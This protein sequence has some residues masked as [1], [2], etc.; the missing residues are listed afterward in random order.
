MQLVPVKVTIANGT[1]LSPEVDLQ[2][3]RLVGVN[4]PGGWTTAA[5]TFQ[6]AVNPDSLTAAVWQDLYDEAGVV[7]TVQAAASRNVVISNPALLIGARRIK[8][9]SGTP[10]AAVNQAA[11]RDLYLMLVP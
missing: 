5:L 1:S 6:T 2:G 8:I 9:R 7:L 4:M 11:D 10:A 3:A